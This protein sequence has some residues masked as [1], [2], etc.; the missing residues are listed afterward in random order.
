MPNR[1]SVE[2]KVVAQL[3]IVM[4]PPIQNLL[5]AQH[6]SKYLTQLIIL[7]SRLMLLDSRFESE[8]VDEGWPIRRYCNELVM[9][10]QWP[11]HDTSNLNYQENAHWPWSPSLRSCY[12]LLLLEACLLDA[13]AFFSFARFVG[14]S[15]FQFYQVCTRHWQLLMMTGVFSSVETRIS[16]LGSDTVFL[17]NILSNKFGGLLLDGIKGKTVY[18]CLTEY[19]FSGGL[20]EHIVKSVETS[21]QIAQLVITI[22]L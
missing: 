6:V 16:V 4:P 14:C 18:W 11:I 5:L 20:F 10:S 3:C 12:L 1:K 22:I 8:M 15:D 9:I 13:S 7:S 21:S 19:N 17:S 2:R